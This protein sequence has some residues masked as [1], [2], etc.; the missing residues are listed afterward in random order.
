MNPNVTLDGLALLALLIAGSTFILAIA[1]VI[2]RDRVRIF[3]EKDPNYMSFF[4]I[5]RRMEL[6]LISISFFVYFIVFVSL[7][8]GNFSMP[9][10]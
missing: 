1:S 2:I 10:R 8:V 6:I 4:F 7:F 9:R 5:N 3:R